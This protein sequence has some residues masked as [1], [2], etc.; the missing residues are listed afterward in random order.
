MPLYIRLP[1]YGLK[2]KQDRHDIVTLG[3]V[4]YGIRKGWL[5][6]AQPVTIKALVEAGL[7]QRPRF[8]L[9]LLSRVESTHQGG[10]DL[11]WALNFELSNVSAKASELVKSKGGSVTIKY[12]T[13]LKLREHLYPEKYQL[14]LREPIPPFKEVRKLERFKEKGRPASSQA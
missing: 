10:E 11:Q 13:P 14:P 5:D 2:K 8:G 4:I 6:P 7:V 3:R 9:K 12:R 1:K